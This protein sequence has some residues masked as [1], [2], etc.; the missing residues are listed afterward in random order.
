MKWLKRSVFMLAALLVL[1]GAA[2][3]L[4]SRM[5]LPLTDGSIV[6]AGPHAPV[7]IERDALGVPTI[8]ATSIDDA[9]FGLGFAHAQDR[10]WQLETHKRIGSGRLA[11]AFGEP[12]LENDKFLRAL[13]VKR[14]AARQWA[15]ASPEV[16]AAVLAYTAGI[17]AFLSGAMTARP[18]EF[19]LLGLTPEPWTPE[20]TMAWAAM[21][22]WDLGGNWSTELLRMRL[23]L[24]LPVARINELIPPYPGELPLQTADYAAL[25]R[26]LRLDG[27]LGTQAL[28]AA[29]PSGV[30]GAGSNN[31]VVHGALT[32]TGKPL[33]ANDPHLKLSSPALWYFA[34]LEAPG[35]KVAGATMPGLPVVVLGQNEHIAWG[36]TNTAPDVQDLY[37]ER[38]KPDDPGQYQTPDGW[39]P[40]ETFSE[41]IQVKGKPDVVL[42]VRATRHGPVISD[43]GTIAG[44]TGPADKPSYALAMR[45]TAL[46]PDP[47]TLEA[48]LAFSRATSVAEFIA[49][50]ARYL[51]PMQNMVVADREGRIGMVSAGKVPVRKAENDLKGQVP[52]PGWEARY[53]W[54]GFVDPSQTPRE[55]DPQR[56]W[57]AT[58]NQCI[59]GPEYPHYIT[60]EWA[61]PYRM[62]RIEQLLAARPKHTLESLRDIQADVLSLGT[63]RLLPFIR[64]AQ[65]SHPLAA[66][67]QRQL[68][69]FD[70]T[71]AADRAAP[72]IFWAW[73][74][75]LTLGVLADEIG[76]PLLDR[77]LGAR[78]FRDAIEGV[79]ERDDTFWCD[80]KTTPAGE[81]CARQADAAFS[82]ALDE[83]Q[84]AH[85]PDVSAWQ[86]GNAHQAR[87]EHR[88]FSRVKALAPWFELR[89]PVGGDT[90]TVNSSRV[91][92]RPDAATG[93]MYLNEHGPSL[94]ALYDLADPTKS[95]VMHSSG[96]SGNVFSPL[97]RSFVK[98]WAAVQYVP[99]WS[100]PTEQTLVLTPK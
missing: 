33:L 53:D 14:A 17:N 49:A 89:A 84:K 55:T 88:P 41:T 82:R 20:D 47:G 10:L 51:A 37:I 44:L 43:G 23:A 2:L 68:A 67:A 11:Q 18:P 4:Y 8:K 59:H 31:W 35:L 3:W 97:Y 46:D 57:I 63:V 42:P 5:S 100:A 87:S 61:V 50:S 93:E 34:R 75:Q 80:D 62:Q 28:L 13:G 79:L 76:Q 98:R 64:K 91:A 27:R 21:M 39:A 73:A 38:I 6:V 78:G 52:S 54:A 36:F 74:R 65:S 85:G 70:G 60:S 58:A 32:D 22:A 30:E 48:G 25:F 90:Y 19:V 7:R 99:L 15:L 77:T 29:P 95:R 26:G 45:W 66:A 81:T 92:M 40:F 72:L 94:R 69:D 1:L 12:A 9:V 24:K 96:Q 86:W 83:L 16:R 56:G 71:M